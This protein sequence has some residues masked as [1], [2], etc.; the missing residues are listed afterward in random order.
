MLVKEVNKACEEAFSS[1]DKESLEIERD[2]IFEALGK[3]DIARNQLS[4][5]KSMEEARAVIQKFKQIDIIHI[6]KWIVNPSLRLQAISS[7]AKKM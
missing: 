3:I 4:S 5:K 7:E 6:N 2:S 1:L